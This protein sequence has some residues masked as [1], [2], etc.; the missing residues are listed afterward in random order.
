VVL[1]GVK[2][3]WHR[4][5]DRFTV[6]AVA[7]AVQARFSEVQGGYLAG[8]ITLAAFLSVFPLMLV[9]VA[10][11][12][13]FSQGHPDVT[14]Q[15]LDLL[16][17]PS[18]GEAANTVRQAIHTAQESH[19]AASII[20]VIGLLWSGLS[21]VAAL[22]YAYDSVWQVTG[23]GIRDKGIGLLW[24]GGSAVL[25]VSSFALTTAVRFLPA[26]LA[27]LE[28]VL[29]LGLGFGMFLW[30][31]KILPNR[32]IGWRPLWPG[33]I[34]GAVGFEV[35]KVLGGIY[36][37]HAVRSSS[38]LYGSIGVVFAILAWLFFFGRLI[39][40]A[41][42]LNVVL[43]ERRHGTVTIEVEVPSLPGRDPE[44]GTRSGDAVPA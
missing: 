15:V 14:H 35:L 16:A 29:A 38:A 23:R 33:A 36:L 3:A 32:N 20:G 18:R 31:S 7:A 17:I 26:F 25:F 21:L 39:V 10:V 22:Q 9:A 34:L 41:S 43:W 44:T 28:L 1:D 37:P 13:F 30:A 40:Y 27:P 5:E 4:L 24:L 6:V 42:V 12:G 2:R 11:L 19:R 8:A